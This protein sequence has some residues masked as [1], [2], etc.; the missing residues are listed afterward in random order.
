MLNYDCKKKTDGVEC[1]EE[2]S[3]YLVNLM[4]IFLFSS[5]KQKGSCENNGNDP[6]TLRG[7]KFFVALANKQNRYWMS[8]F[9]PITKNIKLDKTG[10][11]EMDTFNTCHPVDHHAYNSFQHRKGIVTRRR[12]QLSL[13]TSFLQRPIFSFVVS[14]RS[15]K[16]CE[17][18]CAAIY[19]I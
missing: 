2:N 1:W 7:R 15:C 4:C 8:I 13:T 11:S 5:N 16:R 10:Y 14:E 6:W 9:G 19:I 12:K 3:T 18:F 17:N